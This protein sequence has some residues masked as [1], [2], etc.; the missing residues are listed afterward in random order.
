[1]TVLDLTHTIKET[2]PRWPD[3]PPVVLEPLA[4]LENKGF[5][6]MML[7]C[8]THT[9]THVEAP[10]HLLEQG[11]T[12]DALN[13]MQFVGQGM[14]L[15]CRGK[16]VITL[17]ML[18]AYAADLS[19]MEYVLFYTGAGRNWFSPE[20]FTEYPVL[21]EDAARYLASLQLKGVGIDALSFD[22]FVST[23]L[24]IHRILLSAGKVLMENLRNLKNLLGKDF[25]L[26]AA[27]LKI[28]DS[29]AAPARIYALL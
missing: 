6:E 28:R 2:A 16:S 12:L 26:V 24:P 20:Y 3:T 9:G 29:D 14:A 11:A 17:A 8:S 13:P 22:A 4:S 25:T 18:Q 19:R 27:P 23:N 5:R 21:T 1:M 15:D 7:H 10:A